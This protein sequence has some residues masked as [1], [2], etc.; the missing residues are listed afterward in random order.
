VG[1]IFAP[2][3]T[4]L[5]NNGII[6]NDNIHWPIEFYFSG[7]WKFTYLIMRLNAPN[8]QYFCLFC[9]CDIKSR[10]DMSLSWLPSGN[11]KG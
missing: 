8:S 1:K 9:E 4:Y 10:H 5:K 3:L 11:N 6:D 7:D 2:Q